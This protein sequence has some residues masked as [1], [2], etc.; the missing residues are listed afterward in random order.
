[1]LRILLASKNIW[2]ESLMFNFIIM[3]FWSLM[4]E[5][6]DFLKNL[7][8]IKNVFTCYG[9]E[10][11]TIKFAFDLAISFIFSYPEILTL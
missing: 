11:Y 1:M 2:A 9:V 7:L 3:I 4:D 5:S 10:F 8:K 6:K